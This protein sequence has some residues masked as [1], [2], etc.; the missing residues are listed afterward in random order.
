[1]A[2]ATLS[3]DLLKIISHLLRLGASD[4]PALIRL[5]SASGAACQPFMPAVHEYLCVP[6]V[7]PAFLDA[8]MTKSEVRS[9][10]H[11]AAQ[12]SIKRR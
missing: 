7:F 4:D 2:L 5:S 1:V 12:T 9:H 6:D 3:R 10:Y 8:D 11:L